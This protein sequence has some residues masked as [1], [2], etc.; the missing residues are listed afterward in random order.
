MCRSPSDFLGHILLETNFSLK[1]SEGLTKD[2][3][4]NDDIL[5]R[6]MVRSLEIIGEALRG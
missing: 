2:D 6:A 1:Q 4:L 5:K 3:F